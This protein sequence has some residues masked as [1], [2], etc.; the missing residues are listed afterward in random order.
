MAITSPSQIPSWVRRG[1]RANFHSEKGKPA[2]RFDLVIASEPALVAGF[3]CVRCV[4]VFEIISIDA[5]SEATGP[6]PVAPAAAAASRVVQ[7]MDDRRRARNIEKEFR[8]M[9]CVDGVELLV[10]LMLI[11]RGKL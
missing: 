4:D 9:T 2:T 1:A 6:Q 3:Y 7:L 11:V 8:L 5:L 10:R